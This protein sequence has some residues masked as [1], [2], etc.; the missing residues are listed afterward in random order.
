M[1]TRLKALPLAVACVPLLALG[2]CT[3][4]DPEAPQ[5]VEG[6]DTVGA[7]AE[8]PADQDAPR[9]DPVPEGSDAPSGDADPEDGEPGVPA[10][11]D[12]D[13]PGTLGLAVGDCVADVDALGNADDV[14]P[15]DCGDPHVGEV[16]AQ[17][18]ITGKSLFPGNEPLG[19]EAG[20][21]CGGDGF[22]DYVGLDFA[23][24]SL[25]VITMMPSKESWAQGDR[26]VTCVLTD[27]GA[28]EIDGT[29][30]QSLR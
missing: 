24:S 28:D 17:A 27:P 2:A 23:E 11:T 19:Q 16:Y 29:L 25:D 22:T 6:Q 21:I 9:D 8:S 12:P 4:G 10:D 18:D 26:T 7:P 15:A 30:E 14:D 1:R 20:A 13:A 5:G 3:I